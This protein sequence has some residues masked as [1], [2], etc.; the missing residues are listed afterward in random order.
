MLK[1][2]ILMEKKLF[3]WGGTVKGQVNM[4]KRT[5]EFLEGRVTENSASNWRQGAIAS[6]MA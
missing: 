5:K 2:L 1:Q 4:Q 3:F 6:T